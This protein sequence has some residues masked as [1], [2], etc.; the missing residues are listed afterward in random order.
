MS[1]KRNDF[2]ELVCT[3]GHEPWDHVFADGCCVL[4]KCGCEK[5]VQAY[6]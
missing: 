1:Y 2:G 5:F 3:C 6:E 4:R